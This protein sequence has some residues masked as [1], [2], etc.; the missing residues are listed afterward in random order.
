MRNTNAFFISLGL[1]LSLAALMVGA[2]SAVHKSAPV[3]EDKI[4]LNLLTTRL[5]VPEFPTPAP[6]EQPTVPPKVL[7][8]IVKPQTPQT[9]FQPKKAATEQIKPLTNPQMQ[10]PPAAP[11][12]PALLSA[13][14]PEQPIQPPAAKAAPSTPKPQE[15]YEDENLGRIRTIL[16]E[17]LV[18]PKNAQ[19]LKQQGEAVVTFTLEPNREVSQ[20]TITKSSG[21]DLLDDAAKTLIETSASEFPKPQKSV[22]IS[23]P[24]AYKLR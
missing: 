18:Y 11:S 1:H 6:R 9:V 7:Q 12:A 23:L 4:A 21:F 3:P 19:R 14:A 17:K 20:I 24:I 8:P 15:H 13:K 16:M 10:T 2:L 5:P 22:R